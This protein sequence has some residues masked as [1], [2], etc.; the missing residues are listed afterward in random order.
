MPARRAIPRHAGEHRLPALVAR[1]LLAVAV[2]FPAAS[3]AA[4]PP[5]VPPAAPLTLEQI[6]GAPRTVD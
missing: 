4:A 2:A 5:A 1:A 3:A 6:I